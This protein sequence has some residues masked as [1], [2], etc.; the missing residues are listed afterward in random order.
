[1]NEELADNQDEL[2]VIHDED[3]QEESVEE[4]VVEEPIEEAAEDGIR[5]CLLS[6]GLGDVYKRQ[7]LQ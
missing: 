5:Y 7:V 4:E 6:R 1:M 2:E 3:V